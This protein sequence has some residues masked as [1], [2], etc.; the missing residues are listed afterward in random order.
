MGGDYTLLIG[1][2]LFTLAFSLANIPVYIFFRFILRN[3]LLFCANT[4]WRLKAGLPQYSDKPAHS[5]PKCIH[6]F[7]EFGEGRFRGW[8]VVKTLRV[9]AYSAISHPAIACLFQSRHKP[10]LIIDFRQ[11]RAL[12]LTFD[13]Q[14]TYRRDYSWR[15]QQGVPL[16]RQGCA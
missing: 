11:F 8:K 1:D 4:V 5:W 12:G 2:P 9:G 16:F 7:L 14:S 13:E 15:W 6:D 3:D 10:M